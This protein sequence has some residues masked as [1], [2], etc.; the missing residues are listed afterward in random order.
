MIDPKDLLVIDFETYYDADYSLSRKK[1]NT[2]E[3]IR[4]P[5]FHIH[6]VGLKDGTE[7]AIWIAGHD[8]ALRGLQD[9]GYSSRPICAHNTA[10]DAFIMSENVSLQPRM[11]CD[12]LSMARAT[13]GHVTRHDL[14]T[15]AE[16][17]G[18]GSKIRGAL[19]DTKGL[20]ILP[21]EIEERLA[22]YCLSDV[23]LCHQIFWKLYEYM[24]ED[25]MRLIDLT[26]RMFCEPLLEVD[27]YMVEQELA[28]EKLAKKRKLAQSETHKDVFMSNP[29]F[30]ELLSS[31]G[32]SPPTKVSPRTGATTYAFAKNDPGF[33][34]LLCH[35]DETVRLMAETRVLIK[36]TINETRAERLLKAG[37]GGK[38][39]PVLL[40]YAGAHTYRWSGGNKLN[41]QNLIRGGVLRQSIMAPRGCVVLVYDLS[42]IEARITVWL[43]GQTDILDA[44]RSRDAG[45][46][47]DVYSV[48]AAKLFGLP[49]LEVGPELR[50]IG[51]TAVL[52][53]GFGMGWKKLRAMLKIGFLGADPI[54]LTEQEARHIVATYRVG[55]ANVVALWDR[56]DELLQQMA[57]KTDLNHVFGPLRFLHKMIELP[58]GLALRYP[59]LSLDFDHQ[60]NRYQ[61]SYLTREGRKN[62]WGGFLLENIVQALARCVIAEQML[63]VPW[64]IATMTHDELVMVVPEEDAELA[65]AEVRT[66]MTTP[67][68]WAPDLPLA[69]EGGYDKRYTK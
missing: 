6:G 54:D 65:S 49:V 58:S 40:N 44:F 36:S 24:P 48:M 27:T 9:V 25:E 56:L 53:L 66:I 68:R 33:K 37:E 18:L 43:A 28:R 10:F 29:K 60:W 52:G 12:T 31:L 4:D 13:M 32:V 7:P 69:V 62:I 20:R 63:E 38:K 23:E 11:Y 47:E 57:T 35:A 61:I 30:A 1:Y 8:E 39:L 15:V 42:Q 59:G 21:K 16:T 45:T 14:N 22:A 5:Q 34:Q 19:G 2:S 41:L 64:P 3:Y 55:N 26:L 51:K 50:F 46:G 67:P 17:L